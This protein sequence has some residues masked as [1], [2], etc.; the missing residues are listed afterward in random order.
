MTEGQLKYQTLMENQR[1]NLIV[2]KQNAD[3]VKINS[4]TNDIRERDVR[5]KE[6]Q[7]PLQL[8]QMNANIYATVRNANT[9]ERHQ[10][11]GDITNAFGTVLGFIGKMAGLFA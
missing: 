4:R 7:Q 10:W 3:Q 9:N 6:E 5:L 8:E 1:H 2:E 11:I